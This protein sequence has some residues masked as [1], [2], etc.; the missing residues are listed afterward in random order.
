MKTFETNLGYYPYR[1]CFA[2]PTKNEAISIR[3]LEH[4]FKLESDVEGY[5]QPEIN[6]NDSGCHYAYFRASLI[7]LVSAPTTA[8]SIAILVHEINHAVRKAARDIGGFDI[9]H[10]CDEFFAYAEHHLVE[11]ALS[12]V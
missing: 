8:T 3:A 6:I 12:S 4:K 2:W 7:V 11:V 10:A 1:V 5:E 9:A